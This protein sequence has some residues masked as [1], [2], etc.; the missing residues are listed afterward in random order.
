MDNTTTPVSK[1]KT[2]RAGIIFILGM[3]MTIS[4]FAIDMYLP[5]FSK[6]AEDFHTTTARVSLSI[7]SYFFGFA[8]GQL[9]YGPL[10]DR[11]GRKKPLYVGIV[12]YI[13]CC[14]G[15]MVS[16]SVGM[17]VGFRFIQALGGCVAGVAAMTMAR[18]FFPV[19]ESA[20]IF[21]LLILILG[22]SPLLAPTL[23]GFITAGLGWQWVFIGLMLLAVLVMTIVIMFLPTGY[24]P[25]PTISLRAKPMI[26]SF[27]SILRNKQFYT[28][29]LSASFS[30]ATLLVYVAGS[31]LI[32]ME[33]Y[34]VSPQL[35]GGIFA[36]LSVGFIGGNQVN[37]LLLK[38]YKSEDLFRV[39]L[40]S[41]LVLAIIFLIGAVYGWWGLVGTIVMFFL[42]LSTIGLIYP[43]GSALALAPFTTSVGT[44]SAL[45]GFLQ[46][47]IGGVASSCVG[48]FN[49]TDM[50]PILAIEVVIS[51]VANLILQMAPGR[52]KK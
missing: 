40:I 13:I 35:F 47:G 3:L 16:H 22:L 25:D 43:N 44:A 10:L 4:P 28:Y 1:Y 9:I 8:F 21:S 29:T 2:G 7:T 17:L 27:L 24:Q 33:I 20:K 11:F 46:I 18:D 49:S 39:A 34:H 12:I 36:L 31:S 15:C 52:I 14:A 6:I 41:Q 5:A 38:R 42:L 45:L 23:G 19:E 50:V 48:L 30:F 51:L 32:F 37:I 26:N